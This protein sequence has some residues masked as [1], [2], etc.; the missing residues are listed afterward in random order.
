MTERS[1]AG[2]AMVLDLSSF[3]SRHMKGKGKSG[4]R[5]VRYKEAE[6]VQL[7]EQ[8]RQVIGEQAILLQLTAPI[9]VVGDIHGQFNDLQRWFSLA[10]R[11]PNTNYLFLGD[12]VDRGR[13]GLESICLLL[14]FK[15]HYPKHFFLLRGNHECA[16]INRIYGFYDEL[17][18]RGF[19]KLWK[20]FQDVFDVMPLSALIDR[21][22]LCMHGGLSPELTS[23]DKI[24]Q[25]RRPLAAAEAGL[26][27][28]L[29]WS[30][31]E[32]GLKGWTPSLRGIS[33]VFG[34]D[35]VRAFRQQFDIDLIA[36][37][38]QV[39]QN[40]FEFFANQ[41]LVTI[42]S[43]PNYCN[44]FDNNGAIMFVSQ[45]LECKFSVMA[46]TDPVI[47]DKNTHQPTRWPRLR[48]IL[49]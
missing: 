33:Y 49:Q 17:N 1:V 6:L 8:A 14:A 12:Y 46:A 42:F 28:D 11:P 32:R 40:G 13:Q 2:D 41:S 9:V 48:H 16:H 25:L 38:H 7:L 5:E 45:D 19:K 30:D 20:Q 3:I 44:E 15:V 24:D 39:V 10:G 37:A 4:V 47:K 34:T 31:P 27:C 22:I 18:R 29:L 43:A 35:V 36:R 26:A 21:R 23:W